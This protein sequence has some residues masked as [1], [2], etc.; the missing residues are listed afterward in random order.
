MIRLLRGLL[1]AAAW[2]VSPLHAQDA[3]NWLSEPVPA[4]LIHLSEPAANEVVVMINDNAL[5][6][7]HAG[8]FAGKILFDPAGS[9]LGVRRQDKTWSAASLADYARYQT[10]DGLKVRFYR[11]RLSEQALAQLQQRIADALPTPPLFCASAVQNLL[12]GIAPFTA[13]ESTGFTTPSALAKRLDGLTRG[14]SAAGECQQLDATR[15]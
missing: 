15:C 11:F 6:G 1:L 4:A 8:L 14:A 2:L 7:N 13:L 3:P 10:T 12:V 9:Y 5:G